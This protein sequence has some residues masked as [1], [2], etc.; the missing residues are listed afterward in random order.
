[1]LLQSY[2]LLNSGLSFLTGRIS[3]HNLVPGFLNSYSILMKCVTDLVTDTLT[4]TTIF[5]AIIPNEEL[6]LKSMLI[7][8]TKLLPIISY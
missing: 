8:S 2:K 1:M 3:S 4:N 6:N 7:T 5:G